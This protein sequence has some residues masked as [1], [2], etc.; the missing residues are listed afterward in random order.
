MH[1]LV[2]GREHAYQ[3]SSSDGQL[4]RLPSRH[5]IDSDDA[6]DRQP[7]RRLRRCRA[8]GSE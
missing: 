7:T 2:V 3:A 8:S 5:G 1:H 4:G 6:L